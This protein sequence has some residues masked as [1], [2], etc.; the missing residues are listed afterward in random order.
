[1]P[2]LVKSGTTLGQFPNFADLA[3]GAGSFLSPLKPGDSG[4]AAAS[5]LA[6]SALTAVQ[7]AQVQAAKQPA[8]RLTFAQAAARLG[9]T[10][11]N[12]LAP[13]F[14]AFVGPGKRFSDVK[15]EF[16]T[17]SPEVNFQKFISQDFVASGMDKYLTPISPAEASAIAAALKQ[18]GGRAGGLS[19]DGDNTSTIALVAVGIA[20]A[21]GL[22][23]Y[24]K[25]R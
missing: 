13:V 6:T 1:M 7:Q 8:T 4:A 5:S 9:W 17:Q 21:I 24:L 18:V 25:S 3:K 12:A 10:D 23:M 22:G 15:P 2:Y 14:N 19:A 20:A 11:P 16:A